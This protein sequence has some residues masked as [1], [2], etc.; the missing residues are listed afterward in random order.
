MGGNGVA[1]TYGQLA[2][3]RCNGVAWTYGQLA[4]S[5]CNGVAWIYG[6]LAGGSICHGYMGIL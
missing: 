3:S 1:W 5:R 4:G 6:Q 2:G